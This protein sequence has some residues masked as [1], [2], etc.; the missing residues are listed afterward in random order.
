MRRCDACDLDVEGRWQRCPLC[1]AELRGEA[2]EATESPLPAVPLAYSRSRLFR[3]LL[4]VSLGVVLVSFAAQLFFPHEL[5]SLGTT[6]SIWLGVCAMWLVVLTAVRK[7]RNVAKTT[8]YLV[9]IVS[10]VCVYWDYLTGWRQWSLTYTVPVVCAAAAVGLLITVRLMRL[11]VGDYVVY[12]WQTVVFGL[13]PLLFAALG[14]TTTPLAS[15]I[16]GIVI[17]G[18][19]AP[20]ELLSARAMAHEL[21]KRLH[22]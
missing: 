6:R 18:I 13:V 15:I 22:I 14:W 11:E 12:S 20:I 16:C 9:V 1:G 5:A 8:A 7:R 4:L 21:G 17:V 2:T 10:L 19:I 3:I